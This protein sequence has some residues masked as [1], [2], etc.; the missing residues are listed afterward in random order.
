MADANALAPPIKWTGPEP[1]TS[2]A[3]KFFKK[4]C[5]PQTLEQNIGVSNEHQMNITHH[6][7]S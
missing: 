6:S 5:S 3:P 2:T 7:P 4:P 1:A